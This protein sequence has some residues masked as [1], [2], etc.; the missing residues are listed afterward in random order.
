[1]CISW[2]FYALCPFCLSLFVLFSFCS[3]VCKMGLGT[4]QVLI[5]RKMFAY[6]ILLANDS[7]LTKHWLQLTCFA[8]LGIVSFYKVSDQ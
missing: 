1:M 7:S 8:S 2:I 6:H 5:A 3:H 4:C